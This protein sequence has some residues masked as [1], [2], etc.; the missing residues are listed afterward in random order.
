MSYRIEEKDGYFLYK[1]SGL[2]TVQDNEDLIKIFDKKMGKDPNARFLLDYS[3]I[4]GYEQKALKVAYDRME[5][6]FPSG[7]KVALVHNKSG[8]LYQIINFAA[9]AMMKN[10]K[11]FDDRDEAEEWLKET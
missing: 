11:L 1:A 10:A 2:Y 3:S 6:G 7:V 5:K 8:Y 4:T 9:Q